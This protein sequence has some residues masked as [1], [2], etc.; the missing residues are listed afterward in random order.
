MRRVLEVVP[1]LAD[2]RRAAVEVNGDGRN[3]ALGEAQRQLLVEAIEAAHVRE[4][5]DADV[6]RVLG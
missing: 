1:A 3:A 5:H 2:T 4:D 6:A